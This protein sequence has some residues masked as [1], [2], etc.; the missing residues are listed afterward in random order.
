MAQS[1]P[2]SQIFLALFARVNRI[3]ERRVHGDWLDEP[4]GY[5]VMH[6][7]WHAISIA[8]VQRAKVKARIGD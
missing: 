3:F 1:R 4:D 2:L 5:G 7:R 6:P 8:E